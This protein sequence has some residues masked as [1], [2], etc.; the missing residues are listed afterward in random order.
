MCMVFDKAWR[1][2]LYFKDF[3]SLNGNLYLGGIHSGLP[4]DMQIPLKFIL[5]NF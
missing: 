2:F 3:F 5:E 1:K 4:L